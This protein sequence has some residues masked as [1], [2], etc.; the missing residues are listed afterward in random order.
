MMVWSSPATGVRILLLIAGLAA[1]TVCLTE[2]GRWHLSLAAAKARAVP[3]PAPVSRKS[4]PVALD[5][6]EV[7]IL[8]AD[9]IPSPVP[10]SA[11]TPT[12]E[13]EPGA[14]TM[15]ARDSIQ[16][17]PETSSGSRNVVEWGPGGARAI[18]RTAA[19]PLPADAAGDTGDPADA[20][21]TAA[22]QARR[23]RNEA[24]ATMRRAPTRKN[25]ARPVRSS[26][27][28]KRATATS[29]A[30][31]AAS[32]A[33]LQ[34]KLSGHARRE[35]L[36]SRG[37]GGSAAKPASLSTHDA[38]DI[39]AR[40]SFALVTALGMV[41]LGLAIVGVGTVYANFPRNVHPSVA[42]PGG[43]CTPPAQSILS[44]PPNL[45]HRRPRRCSS[46]IALAVVV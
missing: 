40:Q 20:S 45:H 9:R 1:P 35:L 16:H 5:P 22:R 28:S 36:R 21:P 7:A 26:A 38:G 3:A 44:S 43:S 42:G 23:Q 24:R 14:P 2:R 29:T 18:T 27:G 12:F 15:V 34:A 39:S 31:A 19:S 17:P 41:G 11:P 4:W 33:L 30:A 46:S 25:D 6:I 32:A 13:F 37:A 10:S 8:T